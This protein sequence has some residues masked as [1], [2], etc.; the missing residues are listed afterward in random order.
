VRY[1]PERLCGAIANIRELDQARR[2]NHLEHLISSNDPATSDRRVEELVWSVVEAQQLATIFEGVRDYERKIAKRQLEKALTGPLHPINETDSTN[3]GRNTTFELLL[4]TMFRRAGAR[5]TIGEKADLRIDHAGARLY[6]ECKRPVYEHN[7]LKNVWKARGQLQYRFK[8]DQ[9]FSE[10]SNE[11]GGL[12]AISISKALN[13]G[14]K[15]FVVDDAEGL[16]GLGNDIT[17]IRRQYRDDHNRLDDCRLVGMIY[18]LFTP[19]YVRSTRLLTCAS[20]MHV[21]TVKESFQETFPTS[22]EP[23]MQLLKNLGGSLAPR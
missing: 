4:N 20:E 14:Q 18:H 10:P 15:M 21:I 16:E 23:L 5:V 2:E 6:V 12:V 19:A 3:V 17:S 11:V 7:I 13:S 9:R 8:A 1:I 22:G